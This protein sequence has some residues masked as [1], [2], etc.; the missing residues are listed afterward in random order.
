MLLSTTLHHEE[1]EDELEDDECVDDSEKE[2]DG[3]T[4]DRSKQNR[5]NEMKRDGTLPG[6][7]KDYYD[8]CIA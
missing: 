1:E 2:D 6:F 4:V 8:V 3:E 5:F 7:A